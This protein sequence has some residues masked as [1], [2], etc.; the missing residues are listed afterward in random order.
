MVHPGPAGR[1]RSSVYATLADPGTK[2][3]QLPGYAA[4]YGTLVAV[5]SPGTPFARDAAQRNRSRQFGAAYAKI[6]VLVLD[7]CPIVWFNLGM[8]HTCFVCLFPL[9]RAAAPYKAVSSPSSGTRTECTQCGAVH[10]I[11]RMGVDG[12]YESVYFAIPID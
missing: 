8:E 1:L 6:L 10:Y 2:M 3:L 11:A 5:G 9:P 7:R 12:G 4:A